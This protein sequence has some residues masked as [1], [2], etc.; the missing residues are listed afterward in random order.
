MAT[1]FMKNYVAK[2]AGIAADVSTST[3]AETARL[4]AV[5]TAQQPLRQTLAFSLATSTAA[6][7]KTSNRLPVPANGNY[8]LRSAQVVIESGAIG[9]AGYTNYLGFTVSKMAD[10][11]ATT[12]TTIASWSSQTDTIALGENKALVISGANKSIS[13]GSLIA[14][15]T[16][17]G[18]GQTSGVAN[19]VIEIERADD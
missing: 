2:M 6:A 18:S 11:A 13:A 16:K 8:V 1:K 3:D 12:K 7:T 10:S 4:D 14:D 9:A 17:T 5:E 15:L 19:I